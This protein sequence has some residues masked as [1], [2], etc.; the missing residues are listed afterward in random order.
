M[1][2]ETPLLPAGSLRRFA[3]IVV[4]VTDADRSRDFYE[5]FTPLRAESRLEAVEERSPS[6]GIDRGSFVGHVMRDDTHD[7][8][9]PVLLVQW[10]DPASSGTTY[11]SYTN[12]GYF[13]ICFQTP[14]AG[15]L[16]ERVL[17]AG[18]EPLSPLRGPEPG[19][20]TG[21]PVFCVRDPDGTVLEY[22]TLPGEERLYHVNCNTRD[23]D[24]AHE[25][26]GEALGL[27]CVVRSTSTE[28]QTHSFG[29]GGDLNSYDARLYRASD[30]TQDNPA[31]LTLDVVEN[32]VPQPR[33]EAYA[34]PTNVGIVRVGIEVDDV[35]AIR[36]TLVDGGVLSSSKTAEVWQLG[37]DFGRRDVLVVQS[38]DGVPVDLV[39]T[40]AH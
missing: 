30:G 19:R 15:E 1:P 17:D 13:R 11:P 8:S 28:P 16:Y 22:I 6:L 3:W 35:H 26:F 12:P 38:P 18:V 21:R 5:A 23:L 31:A 39:G 36:G 33:G 25:F 29:P 40:V 32:T 4:N 24:R 20:S 9:C 7:G 14:D 27:H 34:A 2:E 37:G 10:I